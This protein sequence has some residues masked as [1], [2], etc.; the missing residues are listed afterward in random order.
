MSAAGST[1]SYQWQLNEVNLYD[2]W[3][4]FGATTP[5]LMI[6]NVLHSDEGSYRVIVHNS[7]DSVAS[8]GAVLTV[9]DPAV[10]TQPASRT[11]I[12]GDNARFLVG[13]AGTTPL[14]YQW[15]LN[16]TDLADATSNSLNTL[17]TGEG[18][19]SVV[20]G[21][22][23][24]N[25]TTSAVATL[26]LLATPG[27][28]LVRWDFNDTN[29]LVVAAPAP[30][31]GTGSA[32]LLNGVTASFNTGTFSDPAGTPGTANSAW[33]TAAYPPQGT[34]SKTAGVQ[35]NVST[36]DRQ[37]ILIAW[38]ERHSDTASKYARLQYTTRRDHLCRRRPDHY[39]FHQQRLGVLCQRSVR[40]TRGQQEP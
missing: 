4:V 12:F 22:V 9:Q 2:G 21:N 13:A 11:N 30:S 36:L 40:R 25:Y 10:N 33:N 6:S 17:A 7:A 14:S 31:S 5:T 18:S 27:D 29:N 20:V 38:E 15:R 26:T 24:G 8:E 32:S 39:D 3:K 28:T 35:F 34:S 16:G 37:D 1:L 23:D 19:Y